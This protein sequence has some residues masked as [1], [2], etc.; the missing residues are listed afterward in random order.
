MRLLFDGGFESS[1]ARNLM[2]FFYCVFNET[3]FIS[4]LNKESFSAPERV[5]KNSS[6]EQIHLGRKRTS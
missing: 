5:F 6:V 3:V 2:R 1:T 4:S